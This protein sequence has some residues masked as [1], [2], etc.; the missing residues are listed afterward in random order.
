MSFNNEYN[1]D[2]MQS[3]SVKSKTINIIE[4]KDE[5][6]NKENIDVVEK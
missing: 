6:F 3:P 5:V 2:I 4:A 1:N